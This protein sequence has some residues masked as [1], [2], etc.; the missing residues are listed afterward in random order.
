MATTDGNGSTSY[1]QVL[2]AVSAMNGGQREQK[3]VAHKFL[4]QFQKSVRTFWRSN[5][6]TNNLTDVD[7]SM[8][9]HY[10]SAAV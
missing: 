1:A 8:D 5:E 4:D 3:L 7:G 9:N 6:V 10:R 2:E